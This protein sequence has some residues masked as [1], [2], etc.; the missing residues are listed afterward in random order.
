M[1]AGAVAHGRQ[2]A[3]VV[4]DRTPTKFITPGVT[5]ECRNMSPARSVW[6]AWPTFPPRP[7]SGRSVRPDYRRRIR[8]CSLHA[9]AQPRPTGCV[10]PART[11]T[12]QADRD[13][14]DAV[15]VFRGNVIY[16]RSY[17]EC[18][19][20]WKAPC[21]NSDLVLSDLSTVRSASMV[22]VS[23]PTVI[24]TSVPG[25]TPGISARIT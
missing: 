9:H 16:L 7:K 8:G 4:I 17:G 3:A 1:A 10:G 15:G 6:P 23:L 21:W 14:Q 25:S 11:A 2:P 19:A 22:S 24:L 13:R 18:I 12:R 20:R 5:G